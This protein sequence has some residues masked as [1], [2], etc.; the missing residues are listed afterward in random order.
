MKNRLVPPQKLRIELPYDP[1]NL[2]MLSLAA[3]SKKS[4]IRLVV[5]YRLEAGVI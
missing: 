3:P 4:L 2:S 1:A 5:S